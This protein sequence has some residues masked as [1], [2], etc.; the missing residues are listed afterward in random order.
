[1]LIRKIQCQVYSSQIQPP[2]MGPSTGAISV[3]MDHRPMAAGAMR[4]GKMRSSSDWDSGISGPP[5]RPCK[6]RAN[7]SMPSELARPHS[8]D[9]RPNRPMA[10]ANTRTAP[11]RA[12]SQPVSGTVMA[13]ATA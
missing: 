5:A 1:M 12:A 8:S 3:V 7:T 10:V 2:T 11:K 9:A 13:S 6:I 4:G